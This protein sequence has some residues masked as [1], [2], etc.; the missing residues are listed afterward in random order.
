MRRLVL[1]RHAQAEHH[2]M[3]GDKG[4]GLTPRGVQQAQEVGVELRRL[5]IDYSL[6]SSAER[7]RQTF[8]ALGLVGPVEFQDAL[9]YEGTDSAIQRIAE[10]SNDVRAL[11]VVGHAPTIPSLVAQLAY[12]TAR[13]EADQAYHFP[14][15]SYSSFSFEGSWERLAEGDFAHVRLDAVRRR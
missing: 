5:G 13:S 15:S 14:T 1:M 12:A 2:S 10:M 9:Y 11:L 7:T 8:A 6:V 3:R 4:R